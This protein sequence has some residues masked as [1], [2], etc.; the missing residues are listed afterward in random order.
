MWIEGW[1]EGD[2]KGKQ[3]YHVVTCTSPN[4]SFY[5]TCPTEHGLVSLEPCSKKKQQRTIGGEAGRSMKGEGGREEGN[6]Q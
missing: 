6:R 2:G 3:R 4:R 1:P 5:P